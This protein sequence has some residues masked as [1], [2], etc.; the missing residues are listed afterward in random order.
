MSLTVVCPACEEHSELEADPAP[1]D[2]P[3]AGATC[4]ACGTLLETAGVDAGSSEDALPDV[5]P[6]PLG[7]DPT[8]M[9][10]IAHVGRYLLFD[11][12]AKGGMATVHLG[13]L[14]GAGGFS[15]VVAIKRL[16]RH[17]LKDAEFTRMLLTEAR[18]AARIR[19]PNVIPMLDVVSDA[20][21]V[22]LV[23][24]Y[25]DGESLSPVCR[26]LAKQ[27]QEVPFDIVTRVMA[28]VLNGLHAVHEA[29]DEKGK[30]IGLI[31]RDV[32]PQNIMVG[33]EGAGR[34]FDFGVAKAMQHVE[35][36]APHSI[37]GK[38]AYMSP[39]QIRGESLTHHS[40]IFAAGICTWELITLRR[41]F[42][43]A[44]ERDR[45]DR[46]QAGHYPAPSE[47]RDDV[48]EALDRVVMRALAL[49][50]ADRFDTA[51][52]FAEALA[53]AVRPATPRRVS[54]WLRAAVSDSLD[55][56]ARLMNM[57]ETWGGSTREAAEEAARVEAQRVSLVSIHDGLAGGARAA[58]KPR[59]NRTLA[60]ALVIL[61]SFVALALAIG[62]ATGTWR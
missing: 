18:L 62:F 6:A 36:T 10:P 8:T 41:L 46:I 12:F 28:D 61:V 24:E 2:D 33:T 11:E 1:D 25:V 59:P 14:D 55:H 44:N 16:H 54:E 56:R 29:V 43:A 34:I 13:R 58:A 57:V 47:R 23:M 19:H 38:S 53:E 27:Y 15:R 7:L 4:P 17:L 60:L 40:D 30:R 20:G 42:G 49:D 5:Q 35:H 50:P 31:H 26:R 39:E 9:Q 37:K 21:E 51:Q 52:E 22:L 45:M 32:S 48:P 3:T